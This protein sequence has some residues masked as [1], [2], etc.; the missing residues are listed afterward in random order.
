MLQNSPFFTGVIEDRNDPLKLGR[1]KVRV[2][3]LHI[4]DKTILPTEDLPWA[5]IMQPLSGGNSVNAIAPSEG[6]TVMIIFNDYPEN[7]QP[8]VI[9]TL[10]GIP[11]AVAVS[12]DRPLDTPLFKDDITP[13][14]RK[15]PT[16]NTEATANHHGPINAP[17]PT[18]SAITDQAR[19][20]GA[21]TGFGVVQNLLQGT[22]TT[23]G[24]IGT[25]AGSIRGVGN[26]YSMTKN[27]FEELLIGSGSKNKAIEQFTLMITQSGPAG[28][29]IATILNGKASLE[30]LARDGKLSVD[31][32]KSSIK[33]IKSPTDALGLLTN[34][35]Q[36]SFNIGSLIN[37]TDSILGTTINSLSNLSIE[38]TL[39]S[40]VGSAQ[41]LASSQV[42]QISATVSGGLSQLQSAASILGLGDVTSTVQNSLSSITSIFTN[43]QKVSQV[44]TGIY[45]STLPSMSNAG[46]INV[47]KT[48]SPTIADSTTFKTTTPGSTP[49]V[50]GT[51]GGPNFGGASPTIVKPTIDHT[52]YEGGAT[53]RTIP[54]TPPSWWKG[55]IANATKGIAAILKACDKYGIKNLEQKAT[56][57]GIVGGESEWIPKAESAQYSNPQRLMQIFPSTFK[58][59]VS[60]AEQYCNWIK[61]KKG[62]ASDFFNLVYDPANN[63]RQLGNSQ[64]G[65]GGKYYGRGFIQ[66]TGRS[67]YEKF[68]RMSGYN[69]DT[70]PDL[71]ISNYDI[72]AEVAVL[73]ILDNVKNVAPTSHPQYF[74]AA[75]KAVGN[76]SP[77]IS[78]KKMS[79]YEYFYGT[80]SPETYGYCDKVAG[81]SINPYSYHGSVADDRNRTDGF[82]DPHNKYPL[83]R[84]LFEPE[85]HRLARGV[86]KETIVPLKESRRTL[87][88]PIANGG[89][90][91]DQPHTPYGAKYPFNRVVETESGHVQEWDDT[92]GYERVHTYHRTGTFEEIDANGTKVTKI[93]GDG[94]VIMDR[95]GFISVSGTANVTVGGNI[96]VYC[97]SNANIEVAG[98]AEMKVGG[99]FDIG[100]ARDMNIAVEGNLSMWANGS[101]NLQAKN[102]GHILSNDNLYVSST[103]NVHIQSDQNMYINSKLTQ[104]IKSETNTF[105]DSSANIHLK[106]GQTIYNQAE[107]NINVKS[108]EQIYINSGNKTNIKAGNNVEVDGSNI[109]LNSGTSASASSATDATDSVKALLHGMIPPVLGSPLNTQYEPLVGPP[110]LGEDVYMYELPDENVQAIK[111][112]NQENAAVHG[113]TNTYPS[114]E[115]SPTGNK[116]NPIESSKKEEILATGMFTADYKLSEHFTLGMMFD[117]GFNNTHKLIAQ[118]GLTPQEI[119]ANLSNLCEN[120]LEKYLPYLPDGIQG[121]GRKW[122]ITSGYRMATGRSDHNLGRACDIQLTGRNKDEHFN[123]IQKLEKVVSY[124]QLILE[125]RGRD[126]VWIH[127]GFRGKPNRKQAFTMV[128]DKYYKNG[129]VL[130]A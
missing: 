111:D 130:L 62:T 71:L 88:V 69:I 30:S 73:F 98:S 129:F 65:D 27:V 123:L 121:Y 39:N 115:Y 87:G 32:I 6:T 16:N 54:T 85:I 79:Y 42:S 33:N 64:P 74:Y 70:N 112:Y 14:G 28:N 17:N 104:H 9:G 97:R 56:I 93:V 55:N 29:A 76:N 49:P 101:F 67:N 4:H 25:L 12:V 19:N 7:Q 22:S 3:G 95:N 99:N 15:I 82:V 57:L 109:N 66:L 120:I 117:G 58:G 102:K 86:T 75:K 72:S 68:A 18:L 36:I 2:F 126:S 110:L 108:G 44:V 26:S 94:Y 45:S 61:G 50:Y 47:L 21:N 106:S 122:L 48:T 96:N 31:S 5:M 119:V 78:A 10:C 84:Y 24:S 59:N 40:I 41:S 90:S 37:G 89:G 52:R 107:N 43:P 1:V 81:N 23:F 20:Q 11:Q 77:D 127:T 91:W 92:P 100:V 124:D 53:G 113:K 13:Q 118:N 105:I 8:I 60:L 116:V 63:G 103:N 125:Y 34:I 128:N 80:K 35:E 38:S 51:Y 114:E 83:K 46:N